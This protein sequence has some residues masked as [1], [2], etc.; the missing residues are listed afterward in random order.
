MAH[1][2]ALDFSADYHG[3][4]CPILFA[5]FAER[6][7]EGIFKCPMDGIVSESQKNPIDQDNRGIPPFAKN[8]K[9]GAPSTFLRGEGWA[10]RPKY[11]KERGTLKDLSGRKGWATRPVSE[12]SRL[13]LISLSQTSTSKGDTRLCETSGV[14]GLIVRG[15]RVPLQKE[16]RITQERGS[17]TDEVPFG[18]TILEDK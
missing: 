18:K 3:K 6:V 5:Y 7:G 11:A 15:R 13:W 9:D 14:L 16:L 12:I 1:P 2:F 17:V 4:G 8:A 10:T